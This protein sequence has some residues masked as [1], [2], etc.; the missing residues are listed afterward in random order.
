MPVRSRSNPLSL[1]VLS[2]LAERPMH[3]YEMAT[4]MRYLGHH[5]TIRLNF[6]SLYTVVRSLE[7]Q[8]FVAAK[9]TEREGRRPTRTVYEITDA[10]RT[11]FID[12]L[13]E[14]L[15]IPVKD[16]PALEAGLALMP[17]LPPDVVVA[18]LDERCRRVELE[19]AR[20]D[21]ILIMTTTR[22]VPRLFLVEIE[23]ERALREAEL[24]FTRTLIREIQSGSIDGIEQWN[25]H[26][27]AEARR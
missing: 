24:A 27:R 11:E 16:Y 23:F 13:S 2:C 10:G 4:T 22:G 25:T 12:W 7:R 17:S 14:L 20:L 21:Q 8:G 19:I 26:H 3:P 5:E 18:L 1:A 15:S 6:G 9:E